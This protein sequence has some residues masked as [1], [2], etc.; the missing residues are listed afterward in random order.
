MTPREELDALADLFAPALREAFLAAIADITDNAILAQV[1]AAI[2]RGD[3]EAAF[4]ALGYSDAAMRPFLA[5]LERSFETGGV[6]MGRTFPRRINTPV[7]KAVFRFDIR[8]PDA[9]KYLREQSAEFVTGIRES[10]RLNIRNT[11]AIGLREGRN[12]RNVALDIV[13]RIGEDG[14]R[15]G[16][17]I[18]LST[19]QEYWLRGFRNSLQSPIA[20]ERQ[21]YFTYELR[22]KRLDGVVQKAIDAGTPL[23][24]DT[25]DKLVT[26]YKDNALRWRGESIGRTE[27]IH[28][29][30]RSEWEATKQAIAMGALSENDVEREWDSAGDKRVRRSHRLLNRKRVGLNEPFV[31]PLTGAKM[32]HPG[33]TSLGASANE[34]IMCRCRVRTV[35]DWAAGVD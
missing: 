7:G 6:Y 10:I 35:I 20:S 22:D 13:G 14:K 28:A 30:N 24:A 1:I 32:M 23:P 27:A 33:D 17:V 11:M 2:E 12:P 5:E 8:A 18:G 19:Q 34:T 15:V 4:H 31:S 21:R 9:E 29:L 3:P 26:R 25:F 16:G